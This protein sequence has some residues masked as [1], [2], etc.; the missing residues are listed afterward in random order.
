MFEK[1]IIHHHQH[2][3]HK[4][5]LAEWQGLDA[6]PDSYHG[7]LWQESLAG[8]AVMGD[9]IPGQILVPPDDTPG[10]A[11]FSNSICHPIARSFEIAGNKLDRQAAT[12][13][14]FTDSKA[15]E[16]AITARF[17]HLSADL[18]IRADNSYGQRF[19][20]ISTDAASSSI[21]ESHNFL[22]CRMKKLRQSTTVL[23]G[24][25]YEQPDCIGAGAGDF[26]FARKSNGAGIRDTHEWNDGIRVRAGG[27]WLGW[28]EGGSRSP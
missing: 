4:K 8:V 16:F 1:C 19:V 15:M 27:W 2:C 9:S 24:A 11:R 18:S 10:C 21:P 14:K 22:I 12:I 25:M 20:G 6:G 5:S 3:R 26:G 28:I 13:L 17:A 7:H 23:E